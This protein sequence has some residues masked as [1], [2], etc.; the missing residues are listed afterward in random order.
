VGLAEEEEAMNDGDMLDTLMAL[1][2]LGRAALL[3]KLHIGADKVEEGVGYERLRGLAVAYDPAR[4]PAR[5]YFRGDTLVMI[6][7][8]DTTALASLEAGAVTRRLGE[9]PLKLRSRAGKKFKH[10]A[11]P[12]QGVAFTFR[13]AE[14][15]LRFLEVFP[16]MA[17]DA[18]LR[19]VYEEPP[20]FRK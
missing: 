19:D 6:Y 4:S 15:P 8:S 1:R 18:Y 2:G 7:L 9:P 3:D 10:Y 17:P 12:E 20:P 13:K 5:F 11:Y 16:P 14:Q